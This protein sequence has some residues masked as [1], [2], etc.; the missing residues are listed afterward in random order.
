[1]KNGECN[2]SNNNSEYKLMQ[3]KLIIWMHIKSD[4]RSCHK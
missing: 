3:K 1:M 4:G 2:K